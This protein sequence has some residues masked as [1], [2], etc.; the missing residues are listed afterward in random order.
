[1]SV[2]L[3]PDLTF[4]GNGVAGMKVGPTWSGGAAALTQSGRHRNRTTAG[5]DSTSHF[6]TCRPRNI[7]HIMNMSISTPLCICRFCCAL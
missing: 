1:M 6:D 3:V 4:L 2:C 7:S 5:G